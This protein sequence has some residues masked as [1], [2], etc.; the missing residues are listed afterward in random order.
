MTGHVA[1]V[2]LSDEAWT[3]TLTAIY[4]ALRPGGRLAFET[5][6]PGDRAW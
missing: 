1:Q 4:D 3:A 2:F 5:R 6:N